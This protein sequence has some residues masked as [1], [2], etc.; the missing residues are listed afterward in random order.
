MGESSARR[1]TVRIVLIG[2]ILGLAVLLGVALILQQTGAAPG[3][4]GLLLAL[5]PLT[6]VLGAIAWLDRWEPEPVPLL[7]LCLL[8]GAGVSIVVA[9]AVNTLVGE[10]VYATTGSLRTSDAVTSVVSA[11]VVEEGIKGLGLLLLFLSRPR[12]FDGIVDGIVYAAT[13]AAGFAFVE[14]ILYFGRYSEALPD[15]FL[16]RALLSP[17]AHVL[18]TVCIGVAVGTAAGRRRRTLWWRYP[19]G[20]VCAIADHAVWNG[21]AVLAPAEDFYLVYG[22]I[23]VPV[24]LGVLAVAVWLRR[25]ESAVIGA[26]LQEYAEVGW[27]TQAE[28][29]MLSSLSQRT[30]AR[31]WAASTSPRARS[32]M[33]TLIRDATSLAYLRNRAVLGRA[34][35]RHHARSEAQLLASIH[36]ARAT[37]GAP[38]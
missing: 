17:F 11:P 18:F 16:Q 6:V 32:A 15:V 24:F 8:W 19:L 31:R 29:G 2:A 34:D 26:R 20:L 10:V 12:F 28:V 13:I 3:V 1:D 21:V 37:L 38:R 9:L 33:R 35:L 36:G 30:R 22:L 23:H 27:F 5:I 7:V 14:N 25:K 4:V